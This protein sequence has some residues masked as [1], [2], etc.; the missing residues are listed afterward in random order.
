ME[1]WDKFI[2]GHIRVKITKKPKTIFFKKCFQ[3]NSNKID[4]I[5]ENG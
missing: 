2:I 4:I 1:L 3:R 5:N